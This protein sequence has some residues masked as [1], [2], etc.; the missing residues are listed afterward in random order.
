ML[1]SAHIGAA[2][3]IN[4]TIIAGEPLTIAGR[5][6]GSIAVKVVDGATVRGRIDTGPRKTVAS[7]I[8]DNLPEWRRQW[9]AWK[10]A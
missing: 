1:T 8:V 10:Q 5:E 9:D 7:R 4:G 2:I 6:E 3:Y